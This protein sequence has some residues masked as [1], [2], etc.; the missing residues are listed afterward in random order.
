MSRFI[1]F[2]VHLGCLAFAFFSV[3]M[4]VS[5]TSS[6]SSTSLYNIKLELTD[7]A[8][9]IRSLDLYRGHPVLIAM[10][11]GGCP[12]VCPLIFEGVHATETALPAATR[13]N[14]RVLMVS[15]DPQ[16]D[17][18][19]ALARL[20]KERRADPARWTLARARER[21]V[22]LLA[23]SLNVQYRRLPNGEYNH[24]SVITLLTPDGRIVKQTSVLTH[25]DPE[26]V[27][28]VMSGK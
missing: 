19:E 11:Y 8:G 21:D 7:Q 12:N 16:H 22:R 13:A 2:A 23:A 18:P 14:M 10:F 5:A 3:T 6:E 28:A 27:A 20:A 4:P 25:A 1:R 17:T 15:I 9:A 24:T 26:L